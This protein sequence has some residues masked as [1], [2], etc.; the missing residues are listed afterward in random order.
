MCIV[1]KK[2]DA[3]Y[4]AFVKDIDPN[5]KPTKITFGDESD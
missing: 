1:K 3:N 2:V 4:G 5:A